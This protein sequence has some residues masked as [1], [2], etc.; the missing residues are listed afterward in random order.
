MFGISNKCEILRRGFRREYPGERDG[1][2]ELV[3]AR[4]ERPTKSLVAALTGV[5][6]NEK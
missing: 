4:A 3:I 5:K 6:E 2:N 1:V